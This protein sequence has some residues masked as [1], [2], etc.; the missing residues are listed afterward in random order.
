M[1]HV[2]VEK[3]VPADLR[4]LVA[5]RHDLLTVYNRLYS[6]LEQRY[7]AFQPRRDPDH[8]E[9][10]HYPLVLRTTGGRWVR[11]RFTVDDTRAQGFLF[12]LAVVA[13]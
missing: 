12:V 3:N 2:V 9:C 1:P 7:P 13:A 4:L 10:F 8:V 6:D 5:D 11:M